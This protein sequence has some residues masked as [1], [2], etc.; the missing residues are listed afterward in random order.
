MRDDS[1]N[2]KYIG[3]VG[4]TEQVYSKEKIDSYPI[5][6]LI[7]S[8]L[9]IDWL[10]WIEKAEDI[11]KELSEFNIDENIKMGEILKKDRSPLN[12]LVDYYGEINLYFKETSPVIYSL[13]TSQSYDFTRKF[14]SEDQNRLNF[15]VY[16]HGETIEKLRTESGKTDIKYRLSLTTE[17]IKFDDVAHRLRLL[18]CNEPDYYEFSL[19]C[20]DYPYS[21]VSHVL[22]SYINNFLKNLK[23]LSLFIPK[24]KKM[25]DSCLLIK[26]KEKFIPKERYF[27]YIN[28]ESLQEDDRFKEKYNRVRIFNIA[29]TVN[30]EITMCIYYCCDEIHTL[31]ILEFEYMCMNGIFLRKCTYCD[32]YFL[33]TTFLSRYCDR[34]VD[35]VNN[36]TCKDIGAKNK[37][38]NQIKDDKARALLRMKKNAYQMRCTRD[39][40]KALRAE[41]NNWSYAANIMLEKYESGEIS[42]EEFEMGIALPPTRKSDRSRKK[43]K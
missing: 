10:P 16:E 22:Y 25:I 12:S 7:I 4:N 15:S 8:L 19:Q 42:T 13:F 11:K 6:H 32:K 36:K 23:E 1:L 37:Y 29:E 30:D 35:T 14:F 34:L 9:D 5:G 2:M 21:Y 17:S 33:P 43:A 3:F 38:N 40:S 41:F 39:K 31:A 26:D 20:A 18:F 28:N 27:S 24:I